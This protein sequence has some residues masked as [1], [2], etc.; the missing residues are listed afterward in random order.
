M[1]QKGRFYSIETTQAAIAWFEPFLFYMYTE[2]AVDPGWD[3]HLESCEIISNVYAA[4]LLKA[5]KWKGFCS[6]A[7]LIAKPKHGHAL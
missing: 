5:L 6:P 7:K 2:L 1:V 3:N 4:I